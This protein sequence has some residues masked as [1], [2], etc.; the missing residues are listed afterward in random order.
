MILAD[1]QHAGVGLI[2]NGLIVRLLAEYRIRGPVHGYADSEKLPSSAT[3][4]VLPWMV[5]PSQAGDVL[6]QIGDRPPGIGAF[7]NVHACMRGE[8]TV[9]PNRYGD[10]LTVAEIDR[11]GERLTAGGALALA[12]RTLAMPTAAAR[13]KTRAVGPRDP[14]RHAAT[15][16]INACLTSRS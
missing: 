1:V 2:A 5:L 10:G 8:V 3:S 12:L 6:R 15:S 7:E 14:P 13:N 9:R 4:T 11:L 16:V